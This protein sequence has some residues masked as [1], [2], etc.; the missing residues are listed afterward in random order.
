[1]KDINTATLL[2]SGWFLMVP[3][4]SDQD[5]KTKGFDYALARAMARPL[6]EWNHDSSYDSA[7]ECEAAKQD[8][9]D[10]IMFVRGK[11]L[12]PRDS[13]G[14]IEKRMLQQYIVSRCIPSDSI[15]LK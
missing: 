4:V 6:S 13:I 8:K 15:Q 7:K 2:L 1:M 12:V 5:V 3:V 14:A 11:P 10:Q 9:I